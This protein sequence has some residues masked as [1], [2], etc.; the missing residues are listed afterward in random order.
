MDTGIVDHHTH[1]YDAPTMIGVIPSALY[2]LAGLPK[3]RFLV[4]WAQCRGQIM[5]FQ[6]FSL[7]Y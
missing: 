6:C 5:I 4:L 3:M 1:K 7:T 2:A